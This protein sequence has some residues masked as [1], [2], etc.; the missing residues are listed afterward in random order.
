VQQ[1]LEE[2]GGNGKHWLNELTTG[3]AKK[4]AG[5]KNDPRGGRCPELAK[6]H[7]RRSYNFPSKHRNLQPRLAT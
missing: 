7:Q 5:N 1:L 3:C 2:R 6:V 4:R